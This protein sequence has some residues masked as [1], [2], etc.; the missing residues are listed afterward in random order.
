MME[1]DPSSEVSHNCKY[2]Q[3]NGK[4]AIVTSLSKATHEDN[5]KYSMHDFELLKTL[6]MKSS[7]FWDIMPWRPLKVNHVRV[8]KIK[9]SNK[10]ICSK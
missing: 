7:I 2:T 1:A 6:V 3:G 5:D 10:R 4:Q 9:P 8:R